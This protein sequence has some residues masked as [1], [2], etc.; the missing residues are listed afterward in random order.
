MAAQEMQGQLLQYDL[1]L[2][3]VKLKRELQADADFYIAR[4]REL[5]MKYAVLDDSGNVRLTPQGTFLFK[6]PAQGADYERDRRE[7][8]ETD[9]GAAPAAY[10]AKAP[11][12]AKPY[13]IEALRGFIDFEGEI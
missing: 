5:I 9:A 3:L 1:A 7:L 2:A 13:W 12:E 11:A 10:K 4:E 6:D 8:G